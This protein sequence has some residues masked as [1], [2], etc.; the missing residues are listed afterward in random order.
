MEGRTG[1]RAGVRMKMR[2]R[3]V[4]CREGRRGRPQAFL[5]F[6]HPTT[7]FLLLFDAIP[8][9]RSLRLTFFPSD[10]ALRC[11]FSFSHLAVAAKLARCLHGLAPPCQLQRPSSARL[12]GAWWCGVAADPT[13]PARYCQCSNG[14][15]DRTLFGVRLM[16]IR[17]A[18]KR[19]ISLAFP[20]LIA[21]S[22]SYL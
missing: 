18:M 6:F 10:K 21:L 19:A 8:G 3:K 22:L 16:D 14:G 15:P 13:E 4:G 11:Q 2:Q 7:P 1:M 17:R 9:T 5:L 20:L 12:P